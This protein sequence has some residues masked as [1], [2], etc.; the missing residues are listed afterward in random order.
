MAISFFPLLTAPESISNHSDFVHGSWTS[1][2]DAN[3][4]V[5]NE[6]L[7][8]GVPGRMNDADVRFPIHIASIRCQWLRGFGRG[9][10][11]SI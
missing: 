6:R 4:I 5:A 11:G 1:S 9:L 2:F 8:A 3:D 7:G 10:T